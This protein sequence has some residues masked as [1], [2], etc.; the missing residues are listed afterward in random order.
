VIDVVSS[1]LVAFGLLLFTARSY[2][3]QII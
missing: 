3:V 2:G 1:G